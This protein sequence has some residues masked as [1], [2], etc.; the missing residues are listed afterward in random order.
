MRVIR[1]PF[2]EILSAAQPTE[3]YVKVV[4][5]DSGPVPDPMGA[6]RK[7]YP[8]ILNLRFEGIE[9]AELTD[10]SSP[11]GQEPL[12]LFTDFYKS[13]TGL[14]LTKSQKKLLK[15]VLEYATH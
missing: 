13:Q 9:A 4:L 5:T 2:Q 12:E 15:E 11:E 8:N 3:D 1:G 6:L 14:D 10:T 7:I